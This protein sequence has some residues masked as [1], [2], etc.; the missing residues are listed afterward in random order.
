MTPLQHAQ[1]RGYD[2]LA[3]ILSGSTR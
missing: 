3:S 1:Q 2:R